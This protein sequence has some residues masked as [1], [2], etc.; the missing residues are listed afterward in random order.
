MSL[1][2]Y[3]SSAGSGKT[4]TLVKEYIRLVIDNPE[5]YRHILAITFTNKAANEM[6]SRILTYLSG[7]AKGKGEVKHEMIAL[8]ESEILA[9]TSLTPELLKE[10]AGKAVA[11]I[12]HGYS[13]FAV[14]TIDS[15][16]LLLV[17][18]FTRELHLPTNFDVE[19]DQEKLITKSV[20]LLLGK[21]GSDQNLTRTL[22]QFVESRILDERSWDIERDLKN[23][24]GILLKESS[25]EAIESIKKLNT[26]DYININR[27]LFD[28]IKK[29]EDEL[30][31]PA[32][33]AM[34]LILQNKLEKGDF[35][36]STGGIYQFFERISKKDF[37]KPEINSNVEKML[38]SGKWTSGKCSS[39]QKTKIENLVPQFVGLLEKTTELA[40]KFI[41]DLELFK[42]IQQNIY[43]TAV[44]GEIEKVME[45]FRENE[46]IVHIS[47]FN[48]RI[49]TIVNAEPIPFIYERLGEKY[50]HFMVDEFQDTSMLQ[51]QNLMPLLENSL[52][53]N[54]FNMIVGDGKQAIYR[55]RN[56]EVEQ[57]AA[58]PKI[59]KKPGGQIAA[60]REQ[61]LI[62]HYDEK[63]LNKNYR[64]RKEVV[65]FN[66]AF[67][68]DASLLLPEHLRK[69][70]FTTD[71]S[72][73]DQ[74]MQY[75]NQ[76]VAQ[77]AI[78]G[79]VHV[80]LL[81]VDDL[82]REEKNLL[83][84][85]RIHSIINDL[86]A[87][88]FRL[89]EIT[90]LTRTNEDAGNVAR[91]LIDQGISVVTNE[92]LQLSAS[93]TVHFIIN[94]FRYLN[95][96]LN[97][98]VIADI[99]MFLLEKQNSSNKPI[100][101]ILKGTQ[102][103]HP[104]NAAAKALEQIIGEEFGFDFTSK[105]FLS[106][107]LYEIAESLIRIFKLNKS[108]KDPFVRFFMDVILDFTS[109]NDETLSDF[110]EYWDEKGNKDSIIIPDETDA[111][112]VMTI[113]KAKG[114]EF[115][116]VIYPFANGNDKLAINEFWIQP[117][118]ADI[119]QLETAL[120]K[121]NKTLGLTKFANLREE[122]THKSFLDLLNVLY[123]AMTRPSERMYLILQNKKDAKG[124]WKTATNFMDIADL[125]YLF[126]KKNQL[127]K[128]NKSIYEFGH[129]GSRIKK[130]LKNTGKNNCSTLWQDEE[131][132]KGNWK[133]TA[134]LSFVSSKNWDHESTGQNRDRGI[135][136]HNILAKIKTAAEIGRA[137]NEAVV[138][139]MLEESDKENFHREI[140]N[141]ISSPEVSHFFD[142]ENLV[143]NEKEIILENG[144]LIRPDRVVICNNETSIIDYKT[145]NVK[146][147]HKTQVDEYADA[148]IKMG[149]QNIRKY[150]IYLKKDE[151][152]PGVVNW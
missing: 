87:T 149:Y 42:L 22:V 127:W 58:L 103:I 6:K 97:P 74:K 16:V 141:I 125:F 62:N 88:D 133:D 39:I 61:A 26:S 131:L 27:Q 121:A 101:D 49:S 65:E 1:V 128:D 5:N 105:Y 23:F 19:L 122:E 2:V 118:I 53:A 40:E 20:E 68:N 120:V 139:G 116:V 77:D 70:Y 67:F 104:K 115:P 60:I 28:L 90:L 30:S 100:H 147:E 10:R 110:L 117:E 33:E 109:K 79:S 85:S 66:N 148:L 43:P 31:K 129:K 96:P 146:N 54:H 107:N 143:I 135:I 34:K 37:S 136:I 140:S 9:G 72:D 41:P 86:T 52:S 32:V 35:A 132:E 99:L 29:Y 98:T 134:S 7:M 55:W 95:D 75:Q 59:Y 91:Y 8:L 106:Q 57:F 111:V 94:I 138:E 119:P 11:N 89:N 17:R 47:E 64:T 50:H 102:E 69:I 14:S 12:L 145:G 24:A 150:L 3:K 81:D 25:V 51:W 84:L 36:Y 123:V 151:T 144:R 83:E 73:P 71:Y 93:G 21:V 4:F 76:E 38:N 108:G 15:F 80:E 113:H 46:N 48:K 18:S 142:K 13:N 112:K 56:G 78:G 82:N 45:E 152:N 114:L 126:L 44:L 130:H 124:E 137:I 63:H 92:A